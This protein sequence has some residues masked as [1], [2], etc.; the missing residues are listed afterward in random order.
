M[1]GKLDVRQES[2]ILCKL[3]NRLTGRSTSMEVKDMKEFFDFVEQLSINL[4]CNTEIF[5][6]TVKLFWGKDVEPIPIFRGAYNN[7]YNAYYSKQIEDE[8][9]RIAKRGDLVN[10]KIR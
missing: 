10:A 7:C 5:Y 6:C 4:G 1:N 8:G 2:T 3:K 9:T